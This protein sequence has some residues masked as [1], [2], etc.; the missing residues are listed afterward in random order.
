MINIG[1]VNASSKFEDKKLS[2][3]QDTEFDILCF[4][5]KPKVLLLYIYGLNCC[6][7]IKWCF[8]L[9]IILFMNAMN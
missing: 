1:I 4:V 3:K 2:Y 5:D 6:V 7:S 9:M 8:L